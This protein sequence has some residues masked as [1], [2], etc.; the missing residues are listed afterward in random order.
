VLPI[1]QVKAARQAIIEM[2]EPEVRKERAEKM[3]QAVKE[4]MSQLEADR[5]FSEFSSSKRHTKAGDAMVELN[6]S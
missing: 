3:E 4:R 6:I 1:V 2:V 5:R